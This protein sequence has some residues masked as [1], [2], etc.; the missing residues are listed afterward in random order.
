MTSNFYLWLKWI[1]IFFII[2]WMAGVFY[3]PRILVHYQVALSKSEPGERLLLMAGKLFRFSLIN[4]GGSFFSGVILVFV[5]FDFQTPW[6]LLKILVVL[7]LF[8]YFL[9]CGYALKRMKIGEKMG[10]ETFW[11]ITNE[12]PV[13]FLFIILYLVLFKPF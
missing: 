12:L 7:L 2:S 1:H 5:G 13:L 10:G 8:F 4:A 9:F 3:L 11:R 6:V